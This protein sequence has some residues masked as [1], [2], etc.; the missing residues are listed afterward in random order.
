MI[1]ERGVD[2]FST[3]GS[4]KT[5]N[6]TWTY[7]SWQSGHEQHDTTRELPMATGVIPAAEFLSAL[8]EIGYDGPIRPEPFNKPLNAMENEEASATAGEAM[9][10]AFALVG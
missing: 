10:K 6:T 2:A 3:S 5:V 9:R 7:G 4:A 8:V 1:I